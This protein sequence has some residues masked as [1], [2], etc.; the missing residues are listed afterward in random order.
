VF[1]VVLLLQLEQATSAQAAIKQ[2][3]YILGLIQG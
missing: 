2:L 3:A 1:E